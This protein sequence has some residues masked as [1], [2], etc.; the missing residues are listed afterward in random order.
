MIHFNTGIN[1]SKVSISQA[2]KMAG[3]GRSTLYNKYI[4][5]GKITVESIDDK[6]MIDVSELIR[7]FGSKIKLD[8]HNCVDDTFQDSIEQGLD[9]ATYK[10]ISM[11]EQQLRESKDL[12]KEAKDREDWLRGQLEKTTH[13]LENKQE[14]ENPKR[15]KILGI[16]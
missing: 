9:T 7:L 5:T 15:K 13:L 10:I 16:F 11:L 1:M 12:L 14:P 8:S 6:K 4:N 3:I 2:A